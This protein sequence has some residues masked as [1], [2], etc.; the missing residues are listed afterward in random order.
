MKRGKNCSR[1]LPLQPPNLNARRRQAYA[2]QRCSFSS[3]ACAT[4]QFCVTED[5]RS[6]GRAKRA[7][8]CSPSRVRSSGNAPAERYK[9]HDKSMESVHS[10]SAILAQSC[11]L[12][13]RRS[14]NWLEN[15]RHG[16]N[17]LLLNPSRMCIGRMT[18]GDLARSCQGPKRRRNCICTF[19]CSTCMKASL[20]YV[21]ASDPG[22]RV[23]S[24][25]V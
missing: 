25:G 7:P 21:T 6:P 4:S 16:R 17:R 11:K 1:H 19:V 8:I 15:W 9:E 5:N 24:D 10:K 14:S 2:L 20:R 18:S 13:V 23:D 12:R 22:S 3:T